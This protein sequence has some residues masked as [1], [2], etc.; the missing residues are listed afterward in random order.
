MKL[1]SATI[2]LLMHPVAP[3]AQ[4][5]TMSVEARSVER[6]RSSI[7]HFNSIFDAETRSLSTRTCSTL[8]AVALVCN[9]DARG[10][11]VR[12]RIGIVL[13]LAVPAAAHDDP[14][15]P[16]AGEP[17]HVGPSSATL[18]F[19]RRGIDRSTQEA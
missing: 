3:T 12:L 14:L 17:W 1:V 8:G 5:A 15:R 13:D 11:A 9:S 10:K 2:L 6:G 7:V 16:V 4:S 18:S 19:N